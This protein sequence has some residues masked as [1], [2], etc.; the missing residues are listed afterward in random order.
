MDRHGDLC[1][2]HTCALYKYAWPCVH[3]KV[4]AIILNNDGARTSNGVW[5]IKK[6][7]RFVWDLKSCKYIGLKTMDRLWK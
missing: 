1:S 4:A 2:H 7:S 5:F 3:S 6:A